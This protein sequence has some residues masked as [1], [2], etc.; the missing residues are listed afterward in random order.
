MLVKTFKEQLGWY[1]SEDSCYIERSQN[2]LKGRNKKDLEFI[3]ALPRI[4]ATQASYIN[5]ILKKFL[6][7]PLGDQLFGQGYIQDVVMNILQQREF[8]AFL[9]Q[10]GLFEIVNCLEDTSPA[11]DKLR[12][13]AA[14]LDF[15]SCQT[16][17]A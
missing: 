8:A 13:Y 9:M 17:T 5:C 2:R 6:D 1:K 11:S 4:N 3:K 15:A 16:K 14:I 7:N 12:T 10:G